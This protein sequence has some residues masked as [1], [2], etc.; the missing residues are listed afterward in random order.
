M[1]NSKVKTMEYIGDDDWGNHV[2]KCIETGVLYKD[3]LG[4]CTEPELCTCG[5]DMDGEPGW[6]LKGDFKI[7]YKSKYDYQEKAY[8]FDYRMLSRLQCDCNYYLGNGHRYAKHLWAGN[9]KAQIEKMKELYKGF[10]DDKK[11]EWLT[12][13][14]ILE[15]EKEMVTEKLVKG[16]F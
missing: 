12:W 5:N 8:E 13:E 16:K 11:P 14:Q 9:K 6:P 10:P 2:Y 3:L 15:Y 7:R 4:G 1:K